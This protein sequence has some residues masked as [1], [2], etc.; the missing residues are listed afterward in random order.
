MGFGSVLMKVKDS[1]LID[2][3]LKRCD[4]SSGSREDA[5]AVNDNVHY[6]GR[7]DG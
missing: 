2:H 3:G 4:M 6:A 7:A 1:L 5:I